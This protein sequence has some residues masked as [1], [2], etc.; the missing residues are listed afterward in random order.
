MTNGYIAFSELTYI[1]VIP[2]PGKCAIQNVRIHWQI[3]ESQKLD[4]WR[5]VA[6]MRGS[7]TMQPVKQIQALAM[8]T[9]FFSRLSE[10]I[11]AAMPDTMPMVER[12]RAFNWE[13]IAFWAGKFFK[14]KIGT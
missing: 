9:F 6:A 4:V 12:L 10:R 3:I 8:S 1:S 7:A 11:P 14:K 5:V 13:K 2:W